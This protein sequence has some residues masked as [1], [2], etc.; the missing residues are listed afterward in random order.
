MRESHIKGRKY[1]YNKNTG[2]MEEIRPA[3]EAA[4]FDWTAV[5]ETFARV[6]FPTGYIVAWPDD[7]E[8]PDGWVRCNVVAGFIQKL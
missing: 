7:R 4:G 3:N 5:N 8:V 6:G 1:R 2:K